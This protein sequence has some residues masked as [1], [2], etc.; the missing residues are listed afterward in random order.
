MDPP[1]IDVT[2]FGGA[3]QDI[4]NTP[5]LYP[6]PTI[7]SRPCLPKDGF[8]LVVFKLKPATSTRS[9]GKDSQIGRLC[10]VSC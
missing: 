9:R 2:F 8:G 3:K 6:G 10:N 4:E 1:V 5:K 7:Q